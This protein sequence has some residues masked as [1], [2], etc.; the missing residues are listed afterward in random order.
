MHFWCPQWLAFPCSG[1]SVLALG[2]TFWVSRSSF[3]VSVKCPIKM[4]V[5]ISREK[6]IL[7]QAPN[8]SSQPHLST[9]S[10]R[11]V[12]SPYALSLKAQGTCTI[13]F[14]DMQSKSLLPS[15]LC[16]PSFYFLDCVWDLQSVQHLYV[17]WLQPIFVH[18]NKTQYDSYKGLY[19]LI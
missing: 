15:L 8:L 17:D 19:F 1:S 9:L 10:Q 6:H 4:D 13:F 18:T 3:W 2:G 7:L 16:I 11:E 14:P 5:Q 12:W